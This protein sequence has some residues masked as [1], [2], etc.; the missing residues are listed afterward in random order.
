MVIFDRAYLWNCDPNFALADL[1]TG[2]VRSNRLSLNRSKHLNGNMKI[3]TD[4]LLTK[5]HV[6][7]FCRFWISDSAKNSYFAIQRGALYNFFIEIWA[8][9][10]QIE[11]SWGNRDPSVDF[12]KSY[13]RVDFSKAR[14]CM[15]L[16]AHK[17]NRTPLLSSWV[18]AF[19]RATI[20]TNRGTWGRAVFCWNHLRPL[21]LDR[22]VWFT[23]RIIPSPL[24]IHSTNKT[25]LKPRG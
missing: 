1:L 7:L 11:I 22:E 3:S 8:S 5:D 23:S 9:T 6:F 12:S 4:L 25:P 13:P 14:H 24:I 20:Q 21:F 18:W 17:E 19:H 2:W 15:P 16:R 10:G